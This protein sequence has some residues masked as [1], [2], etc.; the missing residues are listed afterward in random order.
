MGI[1]SY[2]V[3][4]EI[5]FGKQPE[6]LE[7]EKQIGKIRRKFEYKKL[8]KNYNSCQETQDFNRMVEKFFGFKTFSLLIDPN[9]SDFNAYTI[10]ITYRVDGKIAKNAVVASKKGFRYRPEDKFCTIVIIYSGF[11]MDDRFTDGEILAIILHE[12]GHNF[13]TAITDNGGLMDIVNKTSYILQFPFMLIYSVFYGMQGFRQLA[14]GSNALGNKIYEAY[15]KACKE[16]KLF[17]AGVQTLQNIGASIN[18]GI[19]TV[20]HISIYAQMLFNPIGVMI[21]SLIS[22]VYRLIGNFNIA[23]IIFKPQKYKNEKIADNFAAMYGYG[24][25]SSTA[26]G[27]METGSPNAVDD[28][29]HNS[30][31]FG[32]LYDLILMP[33]R[34][35]LYL[36]DEHPEYPARIKNDLRMLEDDLN[37]TDLDPKLR[38]ELES[39]IK[40]IKG[41]YESF[42]KNIEIEDS[43]YFL[44]LYWLFLFK[45]F[46]GDIKELF[47][48]KDINS[49][50]HRAY[51]R[52]KSNLDKVKLK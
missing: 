48:K 26:L 24:V 4:N 9:M 51:K 31:I 45:A 16:D 17:A 15:N 42:L 18:L 41:H 8:F 27:K 28:F 50:Y 21:G 14:M 19:N 25:E 22:G 49:E 13:Q 38:K 36:F 1:Y 12:I 29:V 40:E 10:P 37:R 11:M 43:H 44:K 52:G 3:L 47:A 5:Y 39:N 7:M 35:L 46:G 34:V 20:Q 30:P 23:D 2:K 33:T 6:L 32:K